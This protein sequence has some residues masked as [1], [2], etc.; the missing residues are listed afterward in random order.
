MEWL[1]SWLENRVKK[2]TLRQL[3]PVERLGHGRLRQIGAASST[4]SLLD[5][6]SNDYLGL[7]EHPDLIAA[8]RKA[9]EK[10]GTGAGA[11]RL[12]SGDLSLY[13]ELEEKIARLKSKEAGLLF[14]NGYMANTGVIPTL[15]GRGDVIF[16][17]RLNHAS[18]YD[19]C[20]LSGA[21]LKRFNHNDLDHL[22]ML[23]KKERGKSRAL[24]VVESVYSM[25]GDM[26]PLQELV[27]LKERY[28]CLLMVD[29]AHA[30]GLFGNNGGGLIEE[31]GVAAGV[32]IAMGTFGKALG[33]YGAYIAASKDMVLYLLNQARSFVYSTALPPAVAAASLAALE[34]IRNKPELRRELQVKTHL[35]KSLLKKGGIDDD[36]GPTQIVPVLVGES[37]DAVKLATALL[38][39]NIFATAIRPPTVPEG[40]ARIRFSITLH[41]ADDDI[42]NAASVLLQCRKSM[43]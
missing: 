14:G 21:K 10:Y 32:D 43:Q 42:Q 2:G 29:E 33:S 4:Q 28:G 27:T 17:D 34:I 9:L 12:M 3:R 41:H 35:F 31:T 6:S 5:F 25:D 38:E 11:A 22:E 37:H 20:L 13:H 36:L 8:S 30:T 1:T 19:G 7:S 24:I 18:I 16:S 15:T 26:C 40:T 23:L 39:N